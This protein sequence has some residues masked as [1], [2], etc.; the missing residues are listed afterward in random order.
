MIRLPVPGPVPTV[1]L[2]PFDE[3]NE[4]AISADVIVAEPNTLIELIRRPAHKS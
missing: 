3:V 4:V 1:K 2:V